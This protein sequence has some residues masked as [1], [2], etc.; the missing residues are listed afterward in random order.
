MSGHERALVEAGN[1]DH[2]L[3]GE[4]LFR[5]LHAAVRVERLAHVAEELFEAAWSNGV[6]KA[7]LW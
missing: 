5:T 6:Q 7:Y 2:L 4:R 3:H 1:A